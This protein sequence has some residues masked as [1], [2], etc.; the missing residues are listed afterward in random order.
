VKGPGTDTLLDHHHT[1]A[2]LGAKIGAYIAICIVVLMLLTILIPSLTILSHIRTQNWKIYS[3]RVL[4]FFGVT[5]L[6]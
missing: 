1:F 5:F 3:R 4:H 6:K 2:K